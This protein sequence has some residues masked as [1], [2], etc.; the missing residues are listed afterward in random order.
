MKLVEEEEATFGTASK[1]SGAATHPEPTPRPANAGL[2]KAAADGD[3][4]AAEKLIS[5]GAEVDCTDGFGQTALL[6]ACT[7]RATD[8]VELLVRHGARIELGDWTGY[9]PLLVA[10]LQRRESAVDLLVHAGADVNHSGRPDGATALHVAA[11]QDEVGIARILLQNGAAVDG[12]DDLGR[13]ALHEAA[14]RGFGEMV[15]VLLESKALADL[16]DGRGD[17]ALHLS[18]AAESLDVMG[19]LLRY[20]ADVN[21]RNDRGSTVL[22][23]ACRAGWTEAVSLLLLHGADVEIQD[24][25][26]RT[27]LQLATSA[28][29]GVVLDIFTGRRRRRR[30]IAE[31]PAREPSSSRSSSV[32]RVRPADTADSVSQ[33]TPEPTANADTGQK[34]SSSGLKLELESNMWAGVRRD[35][36]DGFILA[37]Y[38]NHDVSFDAKLESICPCVHEGKDMHEIQ[39]KL[40][41]MRPYSM[42]HRIRYA[43]V[44]VMLNPGPSKN[45]PNIRGIMPQADRMEVSEQEIT[46]GK[47]FTV[48]AAGSG[49]PSNVNI[50]MEGSKSRRATFKGVRIIHGAVRDRMHASWRLYEEPGS[51]SGLPEIVRLLLVVHS[52]EE[53][54]VRLGLSV[55]ACHFL[56]L[57]IPRTLTAPTGPVYTVP[58]LSIV[59]AY[60]RESQLR[61]MLDVADRA[62]TVVEEA[63]KLEERFSRAMREHSKQH[64]IL[65]AGRKEKQ[66]QE[67]TE[68]L[69]DSKSSDFTA[70][71]DKI[72]E[73]NIETRRSRRVAWDPEEE[74]EVSERLRRLQRRERSYDSDGMDPRLRSSRRNRTMRDDYGHDTYFG[75]SARVHDRRERGQNTME[76]FSAVGPGYHVSRLA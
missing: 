35:N 67:W 47:T 14:R 70:L 50:S 53:F 28:G 59:A 71:R 7:S 61:Q 22:H 1:P 57:G 66:S 15:E 18:V 23:E 60:E 4:G 19:V 73:L 25:D 31:S 54:E 3:V 16:V 5:E 36:G 75:P 43:K 12:R 65:D 63:N 38:D 8:M 49:G 27:A 33:E 37:I 42:D 20:G 41:F 10:C 2:L 11:R 48:G 9:T 68:I 6:R 62:A 30:R 17:S 55:K 13:T 64:L 45:A 24:P 69:D 29:S 58:K 51:K 32:R 76:H 74:A 72:L 56:T 21:I 40:N 44:D 39:I 52:E 26:G 34:A 46:S